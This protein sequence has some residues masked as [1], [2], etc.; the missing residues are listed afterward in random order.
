MANCAAQRNLV[1]KRDF[2]SW[3]LTT[4]ATLQKGDRYRINS[5]QTAPSG[6]TSSA[7]FDPFGSPSVI[8]VINRS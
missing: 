4:F 3:P 2:R 8:Q 7:A 1:D 5:G 6:L